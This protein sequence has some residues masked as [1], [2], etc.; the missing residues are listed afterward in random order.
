VI[1]FMEAV[2]LKR[3]KI[4]S[5]RNPA[6]RLT[7]IRGHSPVDVKLI[8]TAPGSRAEEIG[9]HQRF[10]H[11]NARYE[12]FRAD[13]ELLDYI[14]E[15][16][17]SWTEPQPSSWGLYPRKKKTPCMTA[18]FWPQFLKWF[19]RLVSWTGDDSRLDT[20]EAALRYVAQRKGLRKP[21]KRF[22]GEFDPTTVPRVRP[23]IIQIPCTLRWREWAWDLQIALGQNFFFRVVEMASWV[24][25]KRRGFYKQAPH[26]ESFRT[27]RIVP[28]PDPRAPDFMAS[29]DVRLGIIEQDG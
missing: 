27:K 24:H 17:K 3:I 6:R 14:R 19:D 21:P 12:W 8:A 20:I 25:A 7:A 11:L 13:P 15:N 22:I 1:Y 4:G 23:T 18:S 29:M 28:S 2:G 16:A 9:L 5:T 10:L 26:L